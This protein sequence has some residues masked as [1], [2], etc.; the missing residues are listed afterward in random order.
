MTTPF[1]IRDWKTQ[2]VIRPATVEEARRAIGALNEQER[3]TADGGFFPLYR[4]HDIDDVRAWLEA[5]AP[6]TP[7]VQP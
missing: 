5:N 4:G 7:E 2:Q 1:K 6:F 3:R